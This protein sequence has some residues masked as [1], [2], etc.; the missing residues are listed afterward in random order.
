MSVSVKAVN[1]EG[2][3]S[4][5]TVSGV[6]CGDHMAGDCDTGESGSKARK[7]PPLVGNL[8]QRSLRMMF[9]GLRRRF[10]IMLM[11]N[12]VAAKKF[13]RK[14]RPVMAIKRYS[15]MRRS[16]IHTLYHYYFPTVLPKR[17]D[18]AKRNMNSTPANT[19][20][21]PVSGAVI[22]KSFIYSFEGG[23]FIA[24]GIAADACIPRPS[25]SAHGPDAC[26]TC[27]LRGRGRLQDR[28]RI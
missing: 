19:S 25:S 14:V 13:L 28:Y 9:T 17:S 27:A 12:I 8:Y 7:Q 22:G 2:A 24:C 20:H 10:A 5:M 4:S 6:A 15:K 11:I 21:Y 3:A 23:R 1:P 18:R 26:H 16:P